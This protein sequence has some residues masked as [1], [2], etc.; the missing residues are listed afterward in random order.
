MLKDPST[1]FSDFSP[2]F[3]KTISKG[4]CRTNSLTDDLDAR[5]LLQLERRI[6]RRLFHKGDRVITAG[7]P[8][9]GLHIV[10]SGFFKSY[11]VTQ[12]GQ[13]R[14]S[15]FPIAGELFGIEGLESG[16]HTS[17]TEAIDTGMVCL[18]PLSVLQENSPTGNSMSRRLLN[19]MSRLMLRDK[20]MIFSLTQMNASQRVAAF[21]IDLSS[22]MAGAGFRSDELRLPMQRTDIASYLGMAEETVCRVLSRFQNQGLVRVNRKYIRNYDQERLQTILED[23]QGP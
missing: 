12:G 4:C 7:K 14:V 23:G 16:F 21:L 10:K 18:I 3:Y 1:R 8:F 19:I 13:L 11:S 17:N 6:R 20:E 22:R 5:Q 15:G 9:R 2:S